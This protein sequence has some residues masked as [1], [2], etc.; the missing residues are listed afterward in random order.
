MVPWLM[1]GRPSSRGRYGSPAA[2]CGRHEHTGRS[3]G[4]GRWRGFEPASH[5]AAFPPSLAVTDPQPQVS[6][7]AARPRRLL[8][9]FPSSPDQQPP[10][11][12]FGKR[13]WAYGPKHNTAL[14]SCKAARQLMKINGVVVRTAL[15]AQIGGKGT[16]DGVVFMF[17]GKLINHFLGFTELGGISVEVLAI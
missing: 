6:L 10:A 16:E 7:T 17:L 13:P 12:S 5:R 15:P 1:T 4:L 14:Q 3:S 9:A 11:T 8:T 2:T